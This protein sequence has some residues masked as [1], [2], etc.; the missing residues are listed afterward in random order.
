MLFEA[1]VCSIL[2]CT[3]FPSILDTMQLYKDAQNIEGHSYVDLTSVTV[4]SSAAT[5]NAAITVYRQ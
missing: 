4:N 2:M 3:H 1:A 5:L